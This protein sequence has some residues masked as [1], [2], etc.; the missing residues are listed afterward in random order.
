MTEQQGG[1]PQGGATPPSNTPPPA[2]PEGGTPEGNTPPTPPWGA[3]ENFDPQRAWALVQKLRTENGQIKGER[4]TFKTKVDEHARA[5]QSKEEQLAGDRDS[6]KSRAETAEGRLMRL[7]I[8]LAKGLTPAQSAR[9]VGTTEDE[10]KAD[11]DAFLADLPKGSG[12][13]TP[14]TRR[15]NERM[16]TGGSD[17]EEEPDEDPRKVAARVSRWR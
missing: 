1:Q 13:T 10:L 5:G 11:A 15:P 14:K 4:D 9:L 12:G 8:G 6:F 7:E 2:G 16:P 17:P 3:D